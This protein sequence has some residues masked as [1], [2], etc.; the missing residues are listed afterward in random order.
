M[1]GPSEQRA[2]A[3]L[4]VLRHDEGVRLDPDRLIALYAGLGE[5]GAERVICRATEELAVRIA[6]MRNFVAS[7]DLAALP[8]AGELLAKIA[9]Q[10]GMATLSRV[11]GDVCTC[12]RSRDM[13]GLAA[14][15]ARLERIGD[16][17]VTAVWDLQDITI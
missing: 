13:A 5:A 17:S 3:E 1:A 6:D 7:G 9:T 16:R 11:A 12:A 8:R 15:L 10:V 4:S 14:T 2:G